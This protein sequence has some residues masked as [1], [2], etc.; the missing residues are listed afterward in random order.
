MSYKDNKDL[1]KFD[2]TITKYSEW[3]TNIKDH[4][5]RT[6]R[7]WSILLNSVEKQ[8]H[9]HNYRMLS[10]M[11]VGGVNGWDMACTLGT[12]L[13]AWLGKAARNRRLQLSGNEAG[14]GLEMWRQLYREYKGSGEL[15]YAS[16]RK[17]LNN[18]PQC[19]SMEYLSEHLD[20]W[21]K[22]VADYGQE[23]AAYAPKHLRVANCRVVQGEDHKISTEASGLAEAEEP[24]HSRWPYVAAHL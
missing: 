8:P 11:H 1:S 2:A 5:S 6:N 18:L 17:L 24:Q 4:L 23:I 16:G 10:Q 20:K 3:A 13:V 22:L 19:K 15:I 7:G 9:H 12:F 14:N 21:T